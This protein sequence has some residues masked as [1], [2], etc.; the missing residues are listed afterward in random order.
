[1]AISICMLTSTVEMYLTLLK[2]GFGQRFSDTK[3]D[4]WNWK[5]VAKALRKIQNFFYSL[6][7]VSEGSQTFRN[8]SCPKPKHRLG[9]DGRRVATSVS[10]DTFQAMEI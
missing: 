1:M 5:E 4:T 7:N 6:K 2:L 8:F 9:R 3:V 10:M